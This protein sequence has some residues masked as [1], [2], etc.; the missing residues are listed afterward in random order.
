MNDQRIA[1]LCDS[2]TDTPE[3]FVHAHDVRVVP[4]RINYSDGTSYQSG[5]DITADE[6]IERF[7]DEIPTTSLP[8]PEAIRQ[9]LEQAKADGYEKAVI[10]TISSGLSA[11]FQTTELVAH[12]MDDFPIVCIDTKNIGLAAGMVVQR[13]VE[14]IESGVPFEE[15]EARL[16]KAAE[17]TRVFFSC[18]TLEYLRKG[19]RINEATY[20]LGSMLNIKPVISCDKQGYYFA[21]KKARGWEKALAAEVKLAREWSVF[22][23]KVRLGI[24]C[25]NA[26]D[27]FDEMEEKLRA[28][29]PNALPDIQRTLIS[30]DLLIHTGPELVGIAVIPATE[31]DPA[32]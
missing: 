8:T 2:G 25:T 31:E 4:L 19:G 26:L 29:V 22:F 3:A 23:D 24:C 1:V 17:N 12:M 20:R 18:K 13:A 21:V 10:V 5:V 15:L 32:R 16:T 11:T 30:P 28:A 9:A 6:V 14:L 27:V 7:K